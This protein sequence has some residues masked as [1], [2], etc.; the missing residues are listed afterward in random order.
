MKIYRDLSETKGIKNPVITTGTFDGVHVGHQKILTQL[1]HEAKKIDG[2]SVVLTFWPHPRMVVFP[3]DHNLQLLNTMEEKAQLLESFGIDHFIIY[4]FSKKFSRLSA[5]EYVKDILVDGIGVSKMAVGYD[6]RFGKNREGDFNTLT[7]LAKEYQFQVQ[8]ISAEDVENV[9]VSSTKIRKALLDGDVSTAK[10]YLNYHYF[11]KGRVVSGEGIGK[12]LGFPTANILVE[13][14]YKLIP[15]IGVYAVKVNLG[16]QVYKG[17]M[18]IGVRPTVANNAPKT[19]EV[20][21][22]DYNGDLY[23]QE[24]KVSFIQRLRDEI[25][26]ENVSQLKDQLNEDK[27]NCLEL[28][29]LNP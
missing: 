18:N 20:H 25:R 1:I 16:E 6:H 2:E 23:N 19:I 26:F 24:I 9:N 7:E 12:Q 22:L 4:P 27:K 11:L 15:K 21:L 14:S 29:S 3:D 10:A 13:D 8:E 5:R 28:F 17:M